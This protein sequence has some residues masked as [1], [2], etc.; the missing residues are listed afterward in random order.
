[1]A[2]GELALRLSEC[3]RLRVKDTDFGN[4]LILVNEGKGLKDRVTMLPERLKEPLRAHLEK[5]KEAHEL[6]LREGFGTVELPYALARKYPQAER[7][8]KWQYV[9]P[10]APAFA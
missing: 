9:F 6:D 3:L 8:F 1:M 7:E 5:V 10:R 4:N 2:D